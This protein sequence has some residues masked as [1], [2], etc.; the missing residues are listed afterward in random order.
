V[1]HELLARAKIALLASASLV[2]GGA[3]A[4]A[5]PVRSLG[6]PAA[7]LLESFSTV[8]SVRELRDGRL[9]VVDSR[10]RIVHL[11]DASLRA[12]TAVGKQGSG[13]GEYQR[14]GVLVRIEGDST[15][16]TDIGNRRLLVFNTAGQPV[17]VV[18]AP[19]ERGGWNPAANM[20]R[21]ADRA[22]R[23]Y[24]VTALRMPNAEPTTP[25]DSGVIVRV[26]RRRGAMDTI[27]RVRLPKTTITT[28]TAG[29]KLTGVSVMRNPLAEQDEWAV[30]P[31]GSVAIARVGDYHVEWVLPNGTRRVG[32][33]VSVQPIPV[34]KRDR[35]EATQRSSAGGVELPDWPEV[36]P[37][38]LRDAASV[39][40][41]GAVW[42][43]R[44]RAAA[45]SVPVYDVFDANG[46]LT[47]RVALASRGRIVGFGARAIY[48][49]RLDED[50]LEYLQRIPFGRPQ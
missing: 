23:L 28:T 21:Y 41:D 32:P 39:A 5:P 49:V 11:V 27:A 10:E 47:E 24:Y 46:R 45:D 19:V 48:L 33:R 26:D 14:P 4:Q 18:G 40:P 6:K 3:G 22:G 34:T 8:E 2:A 36:K 37:P 20:P 29:G 1:T 30:A 31:D 9:L 42:V 16:L 12:A 38:F 15:L 44:T 50:D 13:P 35:D 7:E 43:L 25:P 17:G